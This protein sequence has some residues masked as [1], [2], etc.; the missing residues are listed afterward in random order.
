MPTTDK[1]NAAM[2]ILTIDIPI[3]RNWP[4]AK[5]PSAMRAARYILKMFSL[6][7]RNV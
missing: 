2:R 7:I 3:E 5:K 4:N 1:A 6:A